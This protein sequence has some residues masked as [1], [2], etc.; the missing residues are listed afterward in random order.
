[1]SFILDTFND[2]RR[3]CMFF[4][5]PFGIQ[6]DAL[7][8]S[9]M[10]GGDPSWDTIWDS[11]GRITNDGYVVEA[12][13]PFSSLRFQRTEGEQVWG[14]GFGRKYSRDFDYRMALMPRDRD[15]TC[16]L[17]QV[18]KF[19][20]F[21]GVSPGRNIELD[22]TVSAYTTQD[23]PSFPE[24]DF[25]EADSSV[26]AGLT[27]RW[28]I[29]PNLVLSGTV[30]PD[31][32]Q[33]EADAFQL[34]ANE[35]FALYY[36]EK[37]PFFLEGME[38]FQMRLNPV[39]TRTIAAPSWGLKL[40]GKEGAH[41]LGAFVVQDDLNNLVIPGLHGSASASLDQRVTNA[42][43]RY[44]VDVASAST[45]G[46]VLA[47]R[48]G[49]SYSN[50]VGGL[51][52]DL[53]VTPSDRLGLQILAS[54]TEYPSSLSAEHDQPDGAFD[55]ATY[56]AEFSHDSAALSWWVAHR[57]ID[58][59][60]RSDMGYRPR[61]GFSQTRGGWAYTLRAEAGSWYTNLGTGF[62]Y[63]HNEALDG[64]PLESFLDYWANY[65]GPLRSGVDVYGMLGSERYD[66]ADYDINRVSVSLGL[67]PGGSTYVGVNSAFG[68]AIDYTNGRDA[69]R[70]YMEPTVLFTLV[71]RLDVVLSHEFERLEVDDGRLYT[72]NISYLRAAYQFT[73]RAFL[74]AILQH[75][76]NNYNADLYSDGRDSRERRFASQLLF[77]YKLNPQTV[78]YLGYSD[79]HRNAA[80]VELRQRERTLFAKIGY[81]FV[82]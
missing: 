73:R 45:A 72:A 9:G 62:G 27:A 18:A 36:E 19:R 41:A 78:L 14:I 79:S 61:S 2:Q 17:C 5:N 60:F 56:D 75:E 64:E 22:P 53:R 82:L 23:R 12:A 28:G 59:G 10:G 47:A 30:N 3:G 29:T 11:E 33:V 81:A 24:G 68:K 34:D 35:Q 74:R 31:F 76:D 26:D 80:G 1:L 77:S 70:L 46:V 8:S 13:V 71:R 69:D 52:A 7:D 21:K 40:T 44:R 20:G 65:S 48:G 54:Q 38:H 32:S 15:E 6:G 39:Y 50:L 37:R 58:E 49:D 16:Y 25:E 42:A 57:R 66:G 63:V 43:V 4:V 51:D 55:G 67:W